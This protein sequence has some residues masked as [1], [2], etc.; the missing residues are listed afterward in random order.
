[1]NCAFKA[2]TIT[3]VLNRVTCISESRYYN[4]SYKHPYQYIAHR[5]THA[6]GVVVKNQRATLQI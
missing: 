6:S 1:M 2:I 4:L 3:N 5:T